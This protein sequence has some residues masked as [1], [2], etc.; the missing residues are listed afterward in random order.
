[1]PNPAQ[2]KRIMRSFVMSEISAVDEP[3]QAPARN[4]IMKRDDTVITEKGDKTAE[5]VGTTE[6]TKETVMAGDENAA[7]TAELKKRDDELAKSTAEIAKL[8]AVV[9]MKAA[10]RAHYETLSSA[11]QETFLK[12]DDAEREGILE[13]LAK[14][15]PVIFKSA[16]GTE[17]FKND[18]PRLV[19]L[20]KER[21]EEKKQSA[22]IIADAVAAKIEKRVADI[23]PNLPGEPLA[24]AALVSGIEDCEEEVRK[25]AEDILRAAN[26]IVTKFTGTL[27]HSAGGST[28]ITQGAQD[29]LNQII[30]K[31]ME[32][33]EL[34]RP[35]ATKKVM[36]TP[37]GNQLYKQATAERN[38]AAA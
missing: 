23:M 32:V 30:S 12:Q 7:H 10:H 1:M 27:G 38:A 9:N 36:N 28:D 33:D 35:A 21:D 8:N 34:D 18:D 15:N 4:V 16:N 13:N 20:A 3:A 25:Q 14:A 11:D 22:A 17:Y 5:T 24:K 37:V 6:P 31:V 29:K 26:A 2:K 19:A